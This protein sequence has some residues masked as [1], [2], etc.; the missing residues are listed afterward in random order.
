MPMRGASTSAIA[1]RHE[2]G[3]P[4]EYGTGRVQLIEPAVKVPRPRGLRKPPS[5]VPDPS[6]ISIVA[7]PRRAAPPAPCSNWPDTTTVDPFT[8][9]EET[10]PVPRPFEVASIVSPEEWVATISTPTRATAATPHTHHS[11]RAVR[12]LG[13]LAARRFGALATRWGGASFDNL[14]IAARSRRLLARFTVSSSCLPCTVRPVNSGTGTG[15]DPGPIAPSASMSVPS[16]A[17]A[18]YRL[19]GSPFNRSSHTMWGWFA[20]HADGRLS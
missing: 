18:Q 12:R 10:E 4:P 15:F 20:K 3:F 16:V 13:T 17:L 1:T 9:H 11:R 2:D 6:T 14:W 7:S 5:G 19:L 8:M